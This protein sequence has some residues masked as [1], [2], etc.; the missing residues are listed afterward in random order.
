MNLTKPIAAVAI[1]YCVLL[2]FCWI[3][4]LL[5]Q[6]CVS[7]SLIM[8]INLGVMILKIKHIRI[9]MPSKKYIDVVGG[10]QILFQAA[11]WPARL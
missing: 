4:D 10:M 1:A 8:W 11:T 3:F 7:I 6:T 2:N 9:Y 5:F